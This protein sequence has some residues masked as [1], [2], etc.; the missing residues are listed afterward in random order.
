MISNAS[1]ILEEVKH[2]AD[3][4]QYVIQLFALNLLKDEFFKKKHF[5]GYDYYSQLHIQKHR[6]KRNLESPYLNMD[7]I[8]SLLREEKIIEKK[9]DSLKLSREKERDSFLYNYFIEKISIQFPFATF[10]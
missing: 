1:E 2:K 7:S 3:S 8:T 4:Q 10:E 6:I 5:T 9:I